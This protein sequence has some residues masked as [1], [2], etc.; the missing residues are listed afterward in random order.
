MKK[1]F[2]LLLA[3]LLVLGLAGCSSST[4][5]EE[6]TTET[7]DKVITVA[8]SPVPHAVILEKA[9]EILAKDGWD[10]EITEFEDYVQPIEVTESG[11]IDCNYFAHTPYL[12]NY[13]DEHG[14]TETVVAGIHYE[15]F[16]IYP[17]TKSA[18]ADL[19]DGDT[20]VIPNDG[21]NETRALLL[22]A[23][24]GLI[25]LPEG[26]DATSLVTAIDV[27]ENKLN[28]NIVEAEAAVVSHYTDQAAI[29]VLNGNYAL[30]AG[31][32]V[33]KDSIA[34]E[35][36]DSSAA[37]TYVN[38][39]AVKAGNE[40]NEGVQALVKVLQSQEIVDFINETYDGSVVPYT[41]K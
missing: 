39:V 41:A 19:A 18:L 36:S 26:T 5:T 24:N 40:N 38:V 22:L 21:T 37:E 35:A 25:T 14:T 33:S 28:L 23:D 6:T 20:V 17:G 11:E 4:K 2:T 10:L 30:A 15:P 3:V 34:Y 29:V 31:L 7:E 9:K 27:V 13:N 1:L 16:G 32:S 12:N 8:C